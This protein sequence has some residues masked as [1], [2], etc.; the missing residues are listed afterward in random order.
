MQL[1]PE[2]SKIEDGMDIRL[3]RYIAAFERVGHA[4][5]LREIKIKTV[6]QFYGSRFGKLMKYPGTLAIAD[7]RE[8]WAD[9]YYLWDRLYEYNGNKRKLAKPQ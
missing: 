7:T 2:P 4:L 3:R 5:K 1:N 9:F 8:G 6:D